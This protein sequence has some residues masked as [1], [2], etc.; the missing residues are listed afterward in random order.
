MEAVPRHIQLVEKLKGHIRFQ[1]CLLQRI[2]AF[3]PR[4]IKSA[5]TKHIRA[6][7]AES[8]PVTGGKAQMLRHGLAEDHLIGIV[9][10]ESERMSR[11]GAFITNPIDLIEISV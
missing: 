1:F 4:T 5:D 11:L 9:V 8:V 3:L 10:A 2:S 6:I 7:P